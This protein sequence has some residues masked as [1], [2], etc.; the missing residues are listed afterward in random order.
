[1]MTSQCDMLAHHALHRC[2]VGDDVVLM[3]PAMH[4]VYRHVAPSREDILNVCRVRRCKARFGNAEIMM[5]KRLYLRMTNK[6]NIL[7]NVL[8]FL[9]VS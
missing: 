8:K 2:H 7:M 6:G 3:L 9:L 1:M 4:H 5:V